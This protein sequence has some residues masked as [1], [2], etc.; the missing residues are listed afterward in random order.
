MA[1]KIEDYGLIGNT[2]TCA[3]VSRSGSIDWLCAPRFDSDACFAA[4]VG[5]DEHG[6][7]ALRPSVRVRE[8]RQRYRDDSLVLETEFVCDGGVVRIVRE[9]AGRG[10]K[11]VTV[12]RRLGLSDE[13]L[14]ACGAELRRL[15]GAGGTVRD[16]VVEIPGDHRGRIAEH[17]PALGPPGKL[18]G[19]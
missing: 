14:E 13:R 2:N 11:V 7:W 17:L 9:R 6:C 8:T 5:Y 12:V 16:G 1:S 10:G 4:L 18:A 3:L 15:C 19:G